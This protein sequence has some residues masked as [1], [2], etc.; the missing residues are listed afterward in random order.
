LSFNPELIKEWQ[1]IQNEDDWIEFFSFAKSYKLPHVSKNT[2][3]VDFILKCKKCTRQS[4]LKTK[5]YKNLKSIYHH[6]LYSHSRMDKDE[7]PSRD[8][9]VAELQKLSDSQIQ[10]ELKQ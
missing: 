3:P 4:K 9:C 5:N 1:R 2:E 7:Y 6:Y 8:L 10:G